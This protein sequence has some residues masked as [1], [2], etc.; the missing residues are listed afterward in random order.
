MF[1]DASEKAYAAAVYLR[2]MNAAG[3]L[4][5]RLLCAKSRVAPLQTISLARLELCAAVLGA[6]L[7]DAVRKVES[8]TVNRE[9]LWSD[10]TIALKWIRSSPHLWLTFVATRAT[11]FQKLTQGVELRHV[12]GVLNPI[13]IG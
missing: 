8:Y 9:M 10:S 6:E 12:P 4:T 5:V 2:T 7:L 11:R 13:D 3:A 1:V